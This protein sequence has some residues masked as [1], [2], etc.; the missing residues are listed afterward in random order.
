MRFLSQTLEGF[1]LVNAEA[2]GLEGHRL[3]R[4]DRSPQTSCRPS[5]GQDDKNPEECEKDKLIEKR[6]ATMA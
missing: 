5:E 6:G 3:G 1:G 4:R 2:L